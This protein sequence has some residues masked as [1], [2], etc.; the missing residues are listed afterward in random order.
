MTEKRA[1]KKAT[2]IPNRGAKTAVKKATARPGMRS[3]STN[4]QAPA[5][6][7]ITARIRELEDWRGEKLALVRRLILEA[8]PAIVEEW[9]WDTPVW[10]RDGIVCTGEIYK[11]VVKLTF[12]KGALLADPRHLFN[13]G[14]TGNVRRAI[15]LRAQDDLD[16]VAFRE[17]IREA[18]AFNQENP[19]KHRQS[20]KGSSGR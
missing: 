7:L 15:D 12:A 1:A 4:E 19:P 16:D 18:V 13:A 2:K 10:S 11:E 20:R 6:D 17:L 14:L 9:K 5:S 3:D 8:D